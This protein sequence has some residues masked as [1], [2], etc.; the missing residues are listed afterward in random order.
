M[1]LFF[2]NYLNL[3]RALASAIFDPRSLHLLAMTVSLV[4]ISTVVFVY[5]EGW[6]PLDAA[7]FS[8]MTMATIGFGD[9]VPTTDAGKVFTVLFAT[10]GIG[11]FVVLVS[12]IATIFV[13]NFV[14]EKR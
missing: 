14:V 7:Y 12:T 1:G 4:A 6:R 9:L 11:L 2:R 3:L 8:V 5:L 13:A 10:A